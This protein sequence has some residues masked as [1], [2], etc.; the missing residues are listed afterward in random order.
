LILH[1]CDNRAMA[2]SFSDLALLVKAWHETIK[3]LNAIGI[4]TAHDRMINIIRSTPKWILV[5]VLRVMLATR[6]AEVGGAWHCMQAPDEMHQLGVELMVLVDRSG[7]PA[8]A[9]H[10]LFTTGS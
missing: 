9:L 8:P 2:R 4:K 10:K 5:L 3:V 1:H 7:L 6:F